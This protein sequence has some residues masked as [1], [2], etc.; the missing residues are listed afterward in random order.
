MA[1]EIENIEI[2]EILSY[3][4]KLE[5]FSLPSYKELPSIPLYMEQVVGYICEILGPLSKNGEQAITPFMIN[6]YVK[7][8]IISNP[9]Q[10]KYNKSQIGYLIAISLL[11]NVSSMKDLSALIKVDSNLEEEKEKALYDFCKEL[12]TDTIK[13]LSQRVKEELIEIKNVK[14]DKE[15]LGKLCALAL[16]LYVESAV[17]KILADIIADK[18]N[19]STL[20]ALGSLK[21][22]KKDQEQKKK[23][24]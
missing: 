11:K 2:Q 14:E 7:A 6:N 20:K 8:K 3:L 9:V 21:E 17:N 12:E 22:K 4:E 15:E 18:I 19:Q 24:K 13:V 16:K 1:M 23:N 10:K 5:E